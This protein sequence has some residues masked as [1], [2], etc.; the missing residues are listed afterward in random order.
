M[1]EIGM[2]N[3]LGYADG[4]TTHQLTPIGTVGISNKANWDFDATEA[5]SETEISS[6][7]LGSTRRHRFCGH[8]RPAS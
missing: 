6:A 5:E 1:V 8:R 3:V 4:K 2:G 7:A